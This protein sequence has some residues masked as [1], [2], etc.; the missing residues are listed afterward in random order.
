MGKKLVVALVAGL[1]AFARADENPPWAKCLCNEPAN[2]PVGTSWAGGELSFTNRAANGGA[3][4]DFAALDATTFDGATIR[5]ADGAITVDSL[6]FD[7]TRGL[8][9]VGGAGTVLK[10]IADKSVFDGLNPQPATPNSQLTTWSNLTFT[11][12]AGVRPV[13]R[14]G[15][16]IAMRGGGFTITD[17]T[18]S[19]CFSEEFGGAV[20]APLLTGDSTVTNCA[21]EGSWVSAY[22]GYGGAIYASAAENGRKLNVFDSAF[23]DNAAVN[24]GAI[25]TVR[26]AD[27]DEVPIA[28]VLSGLRFEDN[29]ADYGGGAVFAEGAVTVAGAAED[30]A[31]S[32]F[33]RNAAGYTGGAI[34]V[35]GVDGVARPVAIDI[36]KGASFVGNVASND[37]TWTAGG[38]IAVLTT[39]CTFRAK[40][41]LF[42]RNEI[43]AGGNACY[44][45][46]ISLPSGRH[47]LDT[48]VFDCRTAKPNAAVYGGAVDFDSSDDVQIR[49]CSFRFAAVEAISCY[50]VANL[51][52]TNCVVVGNGLI[53]AEYSDL[54]CE[55]AGRVS[56]GYTAY[57]SIWSDAA[58]AADDF[59]LSDRTT[60][61]YAGA[62]TLKLDG[63]GFNPV[64]GLGLVQP[65][66]TDFEDILYG[67]RPVGY[68][69]GA[70]ETPADGLLAT[71]RGS[72][73]Y[74]GTTSG[75]ANLAWSLVDSDG[76]PV[77]LP[78]LGDLTDLFAVTGWEF[79]SCNAGVYSSTNALPSKR[80]D[81][82]YSV[83]PGPYAF[84]AD[85]VSLVAEGEILPRPVTFL[86]ASA[87]KVYD[88][89]PLTTNEVTW[90][91]QDEAG[92]G[93]GILSAEEGFLS[94]DVTG[95]QTEVGSSPNVFEVVWGEGIASSNYESRV[96]YGTLTVTARD[97]A[98]LMV[99]YPDPF[100]YGG[101]N[102]CPQVT[103]TLTNALGQAVSNLVEGTDFS[104][105]YY[106]NVNAYDDPYLVV[107]PNGNFAG[108]PL[109]NAFTILPRPVTFRSASAEKV[110][111][112]L[113]L[114]TN[115]VAWTKQD[116]AGPGTGVLRTEEGYLSF[117]V[118]GSRT[119]VGSSPNVFEVVWGEGIASSNYESRVE[120]GTLTVTAR[121]DPVVEIVAIKWYHNRSD[122][123]FYPQITL[124]F[125]GGDSSRI[126]RFALTC[127]GVDHELPASCV[128]VLRT[129]TAGDEF[130]FGVDPATFV[131][132][133]GSPE[134]WG[135]V[136]PND[137][138]FGVYDATRPI[139]FSVDVQG[140][141]D[142][143]GQD[144]EV[145][146]KGES[147]ASPTALESATSELVASGPVEKLVQGVK[148][149]RVL[150]DLPEP[151]VTATGLPNGLKIV[152]TPV[153]EQI[154]RSV[155]TVGYTCALSGTPTKAGVYHVKFS[156]KI[157]NEVCVTEEELVVGELPLW[158]Y[159]TFTGWSAS[160]AGG[161]EDVGAATLTVTSA[162]KISG[163]VTVQGKKWTFSATGYDAA[164][165]AGDDAFNVTVQAKN[166][167]LCRNVRVR[168]SPDAFEGCASA[169]LSGDGVLAG[170]HRTV[171]GDKPARWKISKAKFSLDEL[172]CPNVKVSVATSGKVTFSGKLPDGRSASGSST[173]FVDE[174]G[175]F[176]AYLIV[177]QNNGIGG[178]LLDVLLSS[179]TRLYGVDVK[180]GTGLK[181]CQGFSEAFVQG[182]K[183]VWTLTDDPG[184]M[185]TASGLPGGVKVVATAVKETVGR[186]VKTIG[187]TYELSGVPTKVGVY[188]V[189]FGQ[190][191][192]EETRVTEGELEVVELPLW[193]YGTFTGWS[194]SDAGGFED[195]GAATMNVTSAGKIS[196]SV[197]VQGKKWTFSATGYDAAP[198]AEGDAF[199]VTVQAKNGK[200]CRNVFVRVS[201]DAFEGC[202]PADLSG[203]GVLAG[204]HRTVWS[205]KP[206]QWK[207]S[208]AK[209]TLD[210]LGCPNVKV[211]VATSGKVT[212]SG[213]LPDG[214]S[215]SGS[216]TAFV[217][218]SGAFHA[219]L[220]V[221]QKN[222]H[223]G[224]LLDIPLAE[225][226]VAR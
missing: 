31:A 207:I 196:G 27:D 127:D 226:E 210:E 222:G 152:A 92:P 216:S 116:E 47:A 199:N 33:I 12:D 87:E 194:A 69:M 219:Y 10:G 163:S 140:A 160:D 114:T 68:S 48:C 71:V 94:V 188:H 198:S 195:V 221:P 66:V 169:D 119:E 133:P 156:Q 203:D 51:A 129:A 78:G 23:T 3:S 113:P 166:G 177:P 123:L 63:A 40:G 53:G 108:G 118:T 13:W 84:Y 149:S 136:P 89:L 147:P 150:T 46:A 59:N 86:S 200:L 125:V 128:M 1:A 2:L 30:V 5:F 99:E 83:K 151:K 211:S 138:L 37:Y 172:G 215:A 164:P 8:T 104:V 58:L 170:L 223:P 220:I 191:V 193:A 186:L 70:Y 44:G 79:A 161:F 205:D 132:Y 75:P 167:K 81:F 111:D 139:G 9:F 43:Q 174:S 204:L 57:G 106:D 122:G 20:Y 212:F 29:A 142:V 17:C 153:K 73:R 18:F 208:K 115:G 60:A 146:V 22:N 38:A 143:D 176:H 16:A 88:S 209:F 41:V 61:I 124:R 21:F 77:G 109:T 105:A 206:A 130:V 180:P 202:A 101:T 76:R 145:D 201:P 62:D 190:K 175:A 19:N 85:V 137:R 102:I 181:C 117:D 35:N 112:S 74:D 148:F 80:I 184:P 158:A 24:G 144:P 26:A 39:G 98:G 4:F 14:N 120:Y 36:G 185:I 64:A 157:G 121:P 155:K 154:G 179:E 93:T 165:S 25:C 162:G 91:K 82:S 49:N 90:T 100:V 55:M 126:V 173:A 214:R 131:Q 159:G 218:G 217:D 28:L 67:S 34:C 65:G 50:N 56:L 213:K 107:T 97:A 182:V 178:L 15:G 7:P 168:V 225:L 183:S 95:S 197:T 189:K 171:W 192:G 135:F 45:G 110:Y 11:C 42:E 103:V 72:R 6:K 134:N 187:F 52:V 224:F 54:F 96:E 32:A 141:L